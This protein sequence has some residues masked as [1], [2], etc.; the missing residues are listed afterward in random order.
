MAKSN[1]RNR[2]HALRNQPGQLFAAADSLSFADLL[3]GEPGRFEGQPAADY[4]A[5]SIDH[6]NDAL[7]LTIHDPNGTNPDPTVVTLA[8]LGAE[9]AAYDGLQLSDIIKGFGS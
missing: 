8:G 7:I 6:D 5:V 1:S 4:V 2:H 9:Y 3:G